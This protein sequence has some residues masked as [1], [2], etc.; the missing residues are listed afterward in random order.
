MR[1]PNDILSLAGSKASTNISPGGSVHAF[2][3]RISLASGS[4]TV[5]NGATPVTATQL[6]VMGMESLETVISYWEDA[7]SAHALTGV[8]LS[9]KAETEF[10]QEIQ[11]LLDIAYELQDKSELLFL[12]ERSVL[13]RDDERRASQK[14]LSKTH[15]DPNFDSA[16][17]FASALD[18][19]ADLREFE[20]FLEEYPNLE[21]YPLYE[22]TV[23]NMEEQPIPYRCLR[24][25]QLNCLSDTEYLG[26][27]HCIRLAFQYLFKDP[28][29]SKW[30]ADTGRQIL[31][32]LMCLGD[33][34][35]KDF[36]VG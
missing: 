21:R 6:G 26:K 29:N 5:G 23:R 14:G 35:P 34:D 24:T 27:L 22:S 12:D 7:L 13:Y 1:S 32:D 16:E 28:N 33:K 3:D 10:C 36:L 25:D 17:S 11:S 4:L 30:V 9:Q 19:I 20:E 15:S 8:A 2:S 18:Q 31:T